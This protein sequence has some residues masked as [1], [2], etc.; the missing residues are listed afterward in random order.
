MSAEENVLAGKI[1]V[2]LPQSPCIDD[3]YTEAVCGPLEGLPM[4]GEREVGDFIT[5]YHVATFFVVLC[6]LS[7][8]SAVWL[9]A[10]A[11][12]GFRNAMFDQSIRLLK[13]K[14]FRQTL[15][16]VGAIIFVR[17]GLEPVVRLLRNIT[18]VQGAWKQSSEYYMLKE[19]Y[20][21]IEGLL[22]VAAICTL[23]ENFVPSMISVPKRTVHYVVHAVLSLTFVIATAGVIFNIKARMVKETTWQLELNGKITQQ[24]RIEAIDKILTLFTIGVSSILGLQAV[25]LDVNSLLAIGGIGGLAAGLA[26]R[27]L[28]ENL[29]NG[30]IIMSSNPFEV[31]EEVIFKSGTGREVEG[32]VLDVGWYR[33]SIRSFERE[34]YI[35]PNSVFSKTVVLNVTRKNSE[36]RFFEYFSLRPEDVTCVSTIVNDMR[37]VI[38]ANSSV[39]QK[40]HRRVFLN[41]ITMEDAEVYVSFYVTASNRDAF[42]AIKQDFM[43]T[44]MDIIDQHGAEVARKSIRVL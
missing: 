44:F 32:I 21:P 17:L 7:V 37:K 40:L 3:H 4:V 14:G 28:L 12:I 8:M 23:V 2:N 9:Q 35:I 18:G 1:Q 34:V 43:L 11:D 33:T 19:V 25:G 20:R 41:K 29:F 24:R 13:T 6:A 26:G 39:I 5:T 15:A 22:V 30:L 31:G 27:E 36:W 10:T 38:R 16:L 42:M